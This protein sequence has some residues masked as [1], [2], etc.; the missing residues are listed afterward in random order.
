MIGTRTGIGVFVTELLRSM[1]AMQ[2]R[3]NDIEIAVYTLSVRAS[4]KRNA[5]S[6]GTATSVNSADCLALV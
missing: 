5:R 1:Q 4:A 2:Q 6:L 3:G